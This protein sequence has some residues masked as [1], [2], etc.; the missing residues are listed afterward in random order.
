[1]GVSD[2][3]STNGGDLGP[4]EVGDGRGEVDVERQVIGDPA[5]RHPRA[6]DPEGHPDRLLV[7][8]LLAQRQAVLALVPAVVGRDDQVGRVEDAATPERRD[9]P[10]DQLVE[11]QE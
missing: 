8:R 9:H 7:G 10:V 5:G 3:P 2:R 1:M 6:D 11:R 4:S